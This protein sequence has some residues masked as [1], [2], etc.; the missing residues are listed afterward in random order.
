MTENTTIIGAE[1]GRLI[2]IARRAGRRAPME[3]LAAGSITLEAGLMG[4][5]RG[6]KFP[7]RQITV[8]AREDW[9][10]ALLD[11]TDLMGPPDLPW[12]LRR[13]NLLV[14]GI[15][16]PRAKGGVLRIGTVEL[17]ITGQTNPCHRM[18]EA[19]RGL[20]SALHP[21]WRGGVTCRVQAGGDIAIGNTVEIL[22]A[23]KEHTIR[24][25]G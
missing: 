9:E 10:A 14:E 19:H 21:D 3:E 25:P 6:A 1:R 16:L 11:L 7:S 17:L 23:P 22:V 5:S 15:R 24:L 18:E 13:A 20:L 12:T 8:L 2:G 4:D